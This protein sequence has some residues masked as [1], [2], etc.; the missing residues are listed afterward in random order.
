[1]PNYQAS[2]QRT[3]RLLATARTLLVPETVSA[4]ETDLRQFDEFLDVNELGLAFEWLASITYKDQ[5]TCLPLL[6][7]LR[8]AAEEMKLYENLSELD[9]RIDALEVP[10]AE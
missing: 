3:E 9:S 2:W 4:N 10:L 6:R 1:L 5:P 8:S 7:L